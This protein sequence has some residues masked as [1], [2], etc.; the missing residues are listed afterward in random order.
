MNNPKYF[1]APLEFNPDRF[2]SPDF[3]INSYMPFSTGPRNCIGQHM[4][5]MEVRI[6]V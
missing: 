5:K 1:D 2:K 6:A 3:N 4:A